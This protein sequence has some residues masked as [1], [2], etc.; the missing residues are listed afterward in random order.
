MAFVPIFNTMG[1]PAGI[2]LAALRR[3][4]LRFI[5]Q[6]LSV[7]GTLLIGVPLVVMYGLIG[8]AF[9]FLLTG[10]LFTLGQWGCLIWVCRRQGRAP[11]A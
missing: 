7:A 10:V 3:A 6:F 1:M 2:I 9:G 5:T 8:A 11:L 4:K